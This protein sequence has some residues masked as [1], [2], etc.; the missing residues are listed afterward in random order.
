MTDVRT[1]TPYALVSAAEEPVEASKRELRGLSRRIEGEALRARPPAV[2][3]ALQDARHLTES[4]RAVYARLAEHGTPAR[5]FARGLQAWL[6]PGVTGVSLDD[7]DPLVDEWVIV[8]PG[9]APV[10]FAAAD[11]GVTDCDD[12]DR[13]FRYALTRDPEVVGSCARLL[14]L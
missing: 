4:T 11:L 6:A 10:A 5:L 2:A 12:D 9:E 3:A 14:G 8:V 7:D 1:A 13:S